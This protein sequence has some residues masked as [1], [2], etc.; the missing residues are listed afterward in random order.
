MTGEVR[1]LE[2]RRINLPGVADW[3]VHGGQVGDSVV[4]DL[5]D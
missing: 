4:T 3:P 5:G 1:F 2:E